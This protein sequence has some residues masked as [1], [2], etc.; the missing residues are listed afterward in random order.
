[1]DML[2]QME[3]SDDGGPVNGLEHSLQSATRAYEDGADEETVFVALFHDVGQIVSQDNHSEVAAAILRPY[4]SKKNHWIVQHHGEFQ[5]YY[6]WHMTG[7]D[8]YAREKYKDSPYYQDCIDWC[9]KYDPERLRAGLPDQ[10]PGVLRTHREEGHVPQALAGLRGQLGHPDR[11]TQT[12]G[13]SP[14]HPPHPRAS[15]ERIMPGNWAILSL[16][17]VRMAMLRTT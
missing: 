15:R 3:F 9:Y 6:F 7:K 12:H 5:G 2:K 17:T 11:V 16:S 1:M 13:P 14:L 10:T 4:I 8:R